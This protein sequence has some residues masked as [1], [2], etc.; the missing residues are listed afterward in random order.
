MN[1]DFTIETSRG[2]YKAK[3]IE[4]GRWSVTIDFKLNNQMKAVFTFTKYAN[5]AVAQKIFEIDEHLT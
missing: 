1:K 4:D 2:K 5:T 3:E